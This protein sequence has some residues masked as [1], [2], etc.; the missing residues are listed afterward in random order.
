MDDESALDEVSSFHVE[1][2]YGLDV[3]VSA[4][5]EDDSYADEEASEVEASVEEYDVSEDDESL[6]WLSLF[7]S[8]KYTVYELSPPH[9]SWG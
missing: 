2:E 3:E 4:S 5:S 8:F 7:W 9:I 6:S 1:D